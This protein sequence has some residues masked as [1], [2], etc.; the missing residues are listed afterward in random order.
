MMVGLTFRFSMLFLLPH[1]ALLALAGVFAASF[2]GHELA[3]KFSAQA[4]G[5]WAEFRLIPMGA[6]LTLISAIPFTFFKI[7]A[8]GAV[9]ISGTS[10]LR[11]IGKVALV[12]PIVNIFLSIV[13]FTGLTLSQSTF[14]LGATIQTILSWGAGINAFIALFN[15]IPFAIFDGQKIFS[16]SKRV[17]AA[18]VAVAGILMIVNFAL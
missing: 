15:L 17:W 18:T 2:I 14:H 11:T 12:G 7:I 5:L 1:W 10:D 9:M 6:V 13:M 16:W 3:H 8:P 4:Y